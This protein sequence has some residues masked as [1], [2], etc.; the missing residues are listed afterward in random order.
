MS[1][2]KFRQLRIVQGNRESYK[3]EEEEKTLHYHKEVQPSKQGKFVIF[4]STG[5][6]VICKIKL[7]I[8]K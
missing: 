8:L 4:T 7:N 2:D 3:T 5:A 6:K 1:S